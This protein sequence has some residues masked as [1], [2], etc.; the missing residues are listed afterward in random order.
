M[1]HVMTQDFGSRC[2][3]DNHLDQKLTQPDPEGT[4]V[5]DGRNPKQ[6]PDMYETSRK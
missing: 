2:L 5:P 6:P 1:V 3:L 4:Y